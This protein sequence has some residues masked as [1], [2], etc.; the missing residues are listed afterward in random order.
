MSKDYA[1]D[2]PEPPAPAGIRQILIDWS[3]EPEYN[4]SSF[5]HSA[6]NEEQMGA[7]VKKIPQR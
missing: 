7:H 5:T 3:E 2:E 1:S 6:F 4:L